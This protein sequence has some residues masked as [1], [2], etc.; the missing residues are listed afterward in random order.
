LELGEEGHERSWIVDRGLKR[1]SPPRRQGRQGR[2]EEGH[3]GKS[4]KVKA[5]R[6]KCEHRTFNVEHRTLNG[7]G[8]AN[9]EHSTSNIQR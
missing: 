4:F 7:R 8:K 3:W 5:E 6:L 2:G 1:D 9:I